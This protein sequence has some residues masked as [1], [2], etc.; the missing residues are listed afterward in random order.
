MTNTISKLHHAL[1]I[2][3][4][5]Y[6]CYEAVHP[7]TPFCSDSA[8]DIGVTVFGEAIKLYTPLYLFSQI[9]QRKYDYDSFKN[10]CQSIIRSTSFI[11]ANAFFALFFFCSSQYFTGKFYYYAVAYLPGFIA[12]AMAVLIEKPSRRSSLAFYVANVASET[13]F[14]IYVGRGYLRPLKYGQVYIFTLSIA[15]LMMMA[16]KRGFED[17][18]LSAAI[19][20][21]VGPEEATTRRSRRRAHEDAIDLDNKELKSSRLALDKNFKLAQDTELGTNR[22]NEYDNVHAHQTTTSGLAGNFR[23]TNL[24]KWMKLIYS[25]RHP[26]CPHQDRSCL[27]YVTRSSVRALLIGYAVQ[28]GL[29]L[30]TKIPMALKD[31]S[32]LRSTATD[33]GILKFGI[34]LST[35]TCLFKATNCCLRWT[36]NCSKPS[37]CFLA[38]MVAAPALM[39]YPS[40]TVALYVLWKCLE[41][42]FNEGVR[43]GVIENKDFFIVILYG[44]ATSQLFYSA[45]MDPRYMKKSYMAFLDRISH[46]KLHMINRSVLDVFGTQASS[47]YEDYFP[48]LHPKFMSRAFQGSIWVWMIEQK[49]PNQQRHS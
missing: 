39:F 29:K 21:I 3:S 24:F 20:L 19:K 35:F 47:G 32:V 6:N 2:W 22:L 41:A 8:L 49:F 23:N 31:P 48:D 36:T 1:E 40:P 15:T 46:H 7:W 34:F 45:L 26:L 17:D 11:S 10:T 27:Y 12:S 5:K 13:L 42:L 25:A 18:P 33:A 44:L 4:F 9:I 43:S 16:K 37:N 28:L 30:S 38:G 14:R